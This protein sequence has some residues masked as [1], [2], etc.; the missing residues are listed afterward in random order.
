[1]PI[2]TDRNMT[3]FFGPVFHA[4]F[5]E[6]NFIDTLENLSLF[7]HKE[8]DLNYA[9]RAKKEDPTFLEIDAFFKTFPKMPYNTFSSRNPG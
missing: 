1:M 2:T 3:I 4:L 8:F 6:D 5:I 9:N 7:H